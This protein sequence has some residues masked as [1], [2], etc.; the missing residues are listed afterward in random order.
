[1]SG[2]INS[3]NKVKT[4][5]TFYQPYSSPIW[6]EKL[7]FDT[8]RSMPEYHYHNFYELYYLVQGERYYFIKNE[9]YHVE[10]GSFVLVDKY[11]VH[12]TTAPAD[13]GYERI[14]IHF[15]DGFLEGIENVIK[16]LHLL[17][18]FKKGFPIIKLNVQE[19]QFA[20]NVLNS[21]LTE[22]EE[23]KK[24]YEQCIRAQLL[25]LLIYLSRR[26]AGVKR[27]EADYMSSSHKTIS[28]I[29]GFIN[30]HFDDE[31]T[32]EELSGKFHISPHYISRIFK[33]FSGIS[34][35]DYLNNVRIKEAQKLMMSTKMNMQQICEAVGYKSYTHFARE[36]KKITGM[37]P[38]QYKKE[39][40]EQKS[41]KKEK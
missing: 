29:A 37:S 41:A 19:Q 21:I 34:F 1:M 28:E 20:E 38:L 40:K 15:T 13:Y 32:L 14:L 26:T 5:P 22:Y 39:N 23:K 3:R 30:S 33:K 10:K 4:L 31:I 6:V 27:A 2:N 11:D 8:P 16:E 24:G 17:D 25:H 12:I 9:T 36:Y 18:S 7:K 35:V